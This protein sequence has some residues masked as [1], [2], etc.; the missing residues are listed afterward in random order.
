M[1]YGV[2][3]CLAA[4]FCLTVRYAHLQLR[5]VPAFVPI[6][7]S[8]I[9]VNGLITTALLLAQFW[10]VRRTWLL[11]LGSGYLFTALMAVPGVLAFPGVFSPTGLLGGMQ[12]AAWI[13]ASYQFGS[14]VILI[15]AVLVRDLPGTPGLV[16]RTPGLAIALSIALVAATAC[17]LTWAILTYEEVL[18]RLFVNG[19]QQSRNIV[20]VVVPIMALEAA[21]FVLLWRRGRSVLDLWL[22]VMCVAWLL[23]RSLSGPLAGARYSFGWYAGHVFQMAAIFVILLLLLSETTTLYANMARASMQRRG[24][25]Q[26]RQ[27]A[28]D[29]MAASIGHEIRQ[30]LTALRANANAGL[31]Q[32]GKAEPDMTE[33]RAIFSDIDAEGRRIGE[34]ID[35]VRIMFGESTHDRRSLNLNTVVR[36]VLSMVQLEALLHHVVVKTSLENDLPPCLADSGQLHQ[37]FLNL[38]TNAIEA[39]AGV[40]GRPHVLTVTSRSLA[41]S[42]EIAVTVEDTGAGIADKDGCRIFE[43]FFSTKAAGSGVGLTICQVIIKAHGGRLEARANQPH[44][45]VFCVILP[46]GSDE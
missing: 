5:V 37:V 1:A 33:V 36:D 39:M 22:M 46:A 34:I 32:A 38:I 16:Q 24:A 11:V 35:G 23:E 44:G 29:A 28:M 31:R 12:S 8:L 40:A 4:A 10:V 43:P 3:A 2:M 20:L 26:T 14:P 42:S 7:A 9:V 30:P 15:V 21:A 6:Y 19:V 45:T 13:G 17:G 18:P 41:G 25:R 27:I